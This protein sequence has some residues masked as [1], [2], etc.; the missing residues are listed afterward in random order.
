M[1]ALIAHARPLSVTC[2]RAFDMTRDLGRALED[3]IALGVDRVLTS[4]GES[5]ALEGL[6][7]IARL[8][9]QAR[10]R[11]AVMPGGGINERNIGRIVAATDAR[12][13]H[14][15]GRAPV[16]GPMAYRN[17]RAFMGGA[18]RPPE[19]TRAM[20]DAEKVRAMLRPES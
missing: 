2:H 8:T 12:E 10:G 3:L 11:I 14:A 6:D 15:S 16:E 4:G 13:V 18:L 17:T 9:E 7:Q 19:F 5:S 20:V 1:A